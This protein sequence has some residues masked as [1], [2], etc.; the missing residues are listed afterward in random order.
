MP[1]NP[2]DLVRLRAELLRH[3]DNQRTDD[4]PVPFDPKDL[5]IRLASE[6][7]AATLE[8]DPVPRAPFPSHRHRTAWLVRGVKGMGASLMRPFA[9]FL[10]QRQADLNRR[11]LRSI[12]GL[13]ELVR[14]LAERHADR[15]EQIAAWSA[16][17][18]RARDERLLVLDTLASLIGEIEALRREPG[19]D[20]TAGDS[21]LRRL[22]GKLDELT[23]LA[24][25]S[26]RR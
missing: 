21:R 17:Q 7:E 5:F 4:A 14:A 15:D 26:G 24:I 20:G 10:F 16:D 13:V 22:E 19:G 1:L 12:E 11:V 8:V 9:G 3:I 25:A 2:Q 23:R 18:A 6:L